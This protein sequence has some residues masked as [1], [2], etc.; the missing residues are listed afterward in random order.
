MPF[1]HSSVYLYYCFLLFLSYYQWKPLRHLEEKMSNIIPTLGIATWSTCWTENWM[2][3]F[4]PEW[5]HLH[6]SI[7]WHNDG[8][9]IY[10][11]A[12]VARKSDFHACKSMKPQP[13]NS[14][15]NMWQRSPIKGFSHVFCDWSWLISCK[16]IW[17]PQNGWVWRDS[18]KP[19]KS[20]PLCAI[21]VKY[22]DESR[23]AKSNCL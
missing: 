23:G 9:F 1:P 6:V 8:W 17:F 22:T 10:W 19:M 11:T 13:L 16:K 12:L 2:P 18:Q 7:A 3:L 5:Q 15:F 4:S 20:L 21:S 14:F